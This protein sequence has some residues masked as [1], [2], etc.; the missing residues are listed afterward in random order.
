[1][2]HVVVVSVHVGRVSGAFS[3]VFDCPHSVCGWDC[4][5]Q[6]KALL[7]RRTPKDQTHQGWFWTKDSRE[8]APVAGA[9][10][11]AEL[12]SEPVSEC[13][14]GI[15]PPRLVPLIPKCTTSEW[16]MW[17]TTMWTYL[18]TV[19]CGS[20]FG[21]LSWSLKLSYHTQLFDDLGHLGYRRVRKCWCH[22]YALPAGNYS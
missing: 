9:E 12:T 10:Q 20:A 4:W 15:Y 8:S 7:V 19:Q 3:F 16:T 17:T 21:K 6:E 1:M 14:G 5:S 22:N 11:H 2:H 13:S 18:P